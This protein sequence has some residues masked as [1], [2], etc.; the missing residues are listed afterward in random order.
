MENLADLLLSRL[1]IS[2]YIDPINQY[3]EIDIETLKDKLYQYFLDNSESKEFI[4][5][6]YNCAEDLINDKNLLED[7]LE[8]LEEPQDKLMNDIDSMLDLGYEDLLEK[9]LSGKINL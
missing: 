8:L 1:I 3:E 9:K 7:I 5:N 4:D 6:G 2:E